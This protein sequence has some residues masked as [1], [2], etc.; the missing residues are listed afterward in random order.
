M[1]DLGE[2]FLQIK[3]L[4]W[5]KAT[6]SFTPLC[7]CVCVLVELMDESP[8]NDT[9]MP[10]CVFFH[11]FLRYEDN[12]RSNSAGAQTDVSGRTGVHPSF[13][14]LSVLQPDA[15]LWPE[16]ICSSTSVG[17]PP[18]RRGRRP[19]VWPHCGFR[20]CFVQSYRGRNTVELF[21]G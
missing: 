2:F 7:V 11:L 17:V 21:S 20:H 4:L 10:G 6:G 5:L 18:A 19:F 16:G 1:S 3:R 13:P 15:R 12:S 8:H 14:L 9:T